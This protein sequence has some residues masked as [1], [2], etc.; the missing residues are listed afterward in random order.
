VRLDAQVL[1]WLKSKGKGHLTLINDILANLMEVEPSPCS[2]PLVISP[3][4]RERKA[5]SGEIRLARK[6]GT[7]DATSAD[8]PSA[9]TAAIVTAG[10]YGF[11]P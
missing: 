2:G 7:S 5:F 4:I 1:D 8:N 10:L 11:M 9:M 3:S 6:A